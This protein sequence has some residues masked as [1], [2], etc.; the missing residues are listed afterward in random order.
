VA[1][2]PH[3]RAH[4]LAKVVDPQQAGALVEPF[5]RARD[6]AE[7]TAGGGARL[8][9]RQALLDQARCFDLQVLAN[10]AREV[11]IPALSG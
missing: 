5:L 11:L 3:G 2:A 9:G 7:G 10:L 1:D 8:V 6:V 4:V